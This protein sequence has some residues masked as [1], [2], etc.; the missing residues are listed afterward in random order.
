[1]HLSI[2]KSSRET[3]TKLTNFWLQKRFLAKYFHFIT[4]HVIL[5]SLSCMY[6]ASC[7]RNLQDWKFY[8]VS[9]RDAAQFFG[10]KSLKNSSVQFIAKNVARGNS[11][12]NGPN[13]P[14]KSLSIYTKSF[15]G[16]YLIK[17][18]LNKNFLTK[19][20]VV[21]WVALSEIQ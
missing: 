1:M 14:A 17:S 7:T 13:F 5:R 11:V 9:V 21:C 3:E 12:Q 16:H 2:E 19:T 15:S 6:T 20:I 18:Q 10:G 4:C 8:W